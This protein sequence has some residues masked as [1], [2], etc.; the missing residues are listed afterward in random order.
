MKIKL[1]SF[2]MNHFYFFPFYKKE[3]KIIPYDNIYNIN[4]IKDP[5]LN[6]SKKISYL[7]C[8]DNYQKIYACLSEGKIVKIINYYK[9]NNNLQLSDESIILNGDGHF[10]KCIYLEKEFLSTITDE[11]IFLWKAKN[12]CFLNIH[13]LNFIEN[14][15]DIGK[16]NN[17]Y[18][19][20][21][22]GFTFHFLNLENFIIDKT[23]F[24]MDFI[25]EI[26]TLLIIKDLILVNCEK[27]IAI[28]SAKTMET[29]QYIQNYDNWNNQKIITKSNDEKI[30]VFNQFNY[31]SIYEFNLSEMILKLIKKMEISI[32]YEN[33]DD[34]DIILE[35]DY[36]N[37]I[38]KKK[39]IIANNNNI[40]IWRNNLSIITDEI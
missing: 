1:L 13:T 15:Y 18:L 25:K 31:A 23:I 39:Y 30:Y 38:P 37:N 3:L 7:S 8:S 36:N 5:K 29:V 11:S 26:D 34:S 28:I 6:F 20:F 33:D 35:D 22:Q 12:K 14:I 21:T 19:V 10:K 40:I 9:Q 17:K 16:L 4:A 27:G 2:Q 24:N 32:Y